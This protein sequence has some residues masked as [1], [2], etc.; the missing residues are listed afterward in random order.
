VPGT[1]AATTTVITLKVLKPRDGAGGGS[2]TTGV[3]RN[4]VC[5]D[6]LQTAQATVQAAGFFTSA[7]RT[8]PGRA[9]RRSPTAIASSSPSPRVPAAAPIPVSASCCG[10]LVRRAD[11]EVRMQEPRPPVSDNEGS[12]S[13]VDT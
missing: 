12:G 9:A 10:P 2:V 3:V 8:A 4:V 1:N 11:R 13:L 5:E 6:D 7:P